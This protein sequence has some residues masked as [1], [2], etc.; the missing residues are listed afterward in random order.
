MFDGF[1]HQLLERGQMNISQS[2][3]IHTSLAGPVFAQFL[4]E[5]IALL[6]SSRDIELWLA[7]HAKSYKIRIRKP[8]LALRHLGIGHV[9]ERF[10]LS[11]RVKI[12]H[13]GLALE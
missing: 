13:S 4:Q 6:N 3:D 12:Q 8:P 5:R 9:P 2:F 7:H 10:L 11:A 1:L